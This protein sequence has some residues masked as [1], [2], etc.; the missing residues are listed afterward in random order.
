MYW[1][2]YF[3]IL[4]QREQGGNYIQK[5]IPSLP[6]FFL[7]EEKVPVSCLLLQASYCSAGSVSSLEERWRAAARKASAMAVISPASSAGKPRKIEFSLV[8]SWRSRRS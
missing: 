7:E 3:R 1:Y 5:R 8:R 6:L 2:S 4:G